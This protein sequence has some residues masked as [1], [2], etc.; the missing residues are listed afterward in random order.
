MTTRTQKQLI[1]KLLGQDLELEI[2]TPAHFFATPNDLYIDNA[3]A[4]IG[5]RDHTFMT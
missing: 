1:I 2:N 4:V 3:D 5:H